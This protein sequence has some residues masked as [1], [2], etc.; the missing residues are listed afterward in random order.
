[1]EHLILKL[2]RL[3]LIYINLVDFRTRHVS[4]VR[5]N[6]EILTVSSEELGL[7]GA[8][9]VAVQGDAV[10]AG[11]A[12]EEED[13]VAVAGYVGDVDFAVEE[14]LGDGEVGGQRGGRGVVG[15]GGEAGWALGDCDHAV[16]WQILHGLVVLIAFIAIH[17]GNLLLRNPKRIV[18]IKEHQRRFP[19]LPAHLHKIPLRQPIF[20]IDSWY[21][22]RRHQH[23]TLLP[24]FS[25]HH[26]KHLH[27]ATRK[28]HVNPVLHDDHI[29]SDLPFLEF[30]E[31]Y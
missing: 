24:L 19:L 2:P 18:L 27:I 30:R 22:Q 26:L 7:R 9:V 3:I 14:G 1:M 11:E 17:L 4:K 29:E 23:Q 8:D 6:N 13:L 31:L 16:G 15:V 28:S 20:L 21:R 5:R 12:I 10:D 25:F